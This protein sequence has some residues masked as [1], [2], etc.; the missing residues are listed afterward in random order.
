MEVITMKLQDTSVQMSSIWNFIYSLR[1]YV[2]DHFKHLLSKEKKNNFCE[3]KTF[4]SAKK[5]SPHDEEGVEDKEGKN[6]D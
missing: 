1:F 4:R 3:G 6:K 5:M 2:W